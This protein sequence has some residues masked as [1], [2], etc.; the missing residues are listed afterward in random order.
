MI[1]DFLEHSFD[2]KTRKEMLKSVHCMSKE[3]RMYKGKED[4]RESVKSVTL[5][6]QILLYIWGYM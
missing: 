4:L 3:I 6:Y 2:M 1:C 5:K